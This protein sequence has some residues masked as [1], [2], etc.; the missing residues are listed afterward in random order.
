MKQS[1]RKW[2][3]A[4]NYLQ[5]SKM[6]SEKSLEER[7][8]VKQILVDAGYKIEERGD[9]IMIDLPRDFGIEERTKLIEKLE[10]RNT[11]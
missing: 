6:A 11:R 10:A 7:L 8:S 1:S 2:S 5:Q 4:E 3:K 9:E